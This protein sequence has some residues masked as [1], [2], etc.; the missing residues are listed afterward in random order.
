MMPPHA[1]DSRDGLGEEYLS[2][3]GF[4]K[5]DCSSSGDERQ[6]HDCNE[7]NVIKSCIA[8]VA[9]ALLGSALVAGTMLYVLGMARK[10]RRPCSRPHLSTD[11]QAVSMLYGRA[12][13]SPSGGANL[14]GAGC[15]EVR[16]MESASC[17][18]L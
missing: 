15:V 1:L 5:L 11:P 9:V 8:W 4:I 18:C 14:D 12:K 10:A 7:Q 16:G 2:L 13:Q 6:D 17:W 3:L